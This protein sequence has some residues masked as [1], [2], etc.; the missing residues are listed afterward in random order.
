MGLIVLDAGV[1]IAILDASDVH[2][3]SARRTVTAA[4]GSGAALALPASAYAEVLVAPHRRGAE[5]A[6][7]VDAFL[8]ALPARVE[9]ATRAIA[10]IAAELRSKHGKRL[11]L[12][13]ALVAA[14]AIVIGAE[15]MIT[16]DARWPR[17]PV[18]VD[19]IRPETE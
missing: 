15:R 10:A 12:P 19:V 14:T 8:D 5:A 4:L 3:G 1:V 2:H 16:T 17:L 7:S 11:R 6:A 9:P 18:R 13:D